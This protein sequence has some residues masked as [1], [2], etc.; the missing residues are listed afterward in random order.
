MSG[1]ATKIG[2][3]GLFYDKSIKKMSQK[4]LA[5]Q[6]LIGKGGTKHHLIY[7]TGEAK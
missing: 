4:R 6:L 2:F 1:P 5:R 3:P 7:P